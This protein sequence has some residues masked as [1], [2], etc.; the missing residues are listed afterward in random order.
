[1][2]EFVMLVS[3]TLLGFSGVPWWMALPA[4]ALTSLQSLLQLIIPGGRLH[5]AGVRGPLTVCGIYSLFA[6]LCFAA[7]HGMALLVSVG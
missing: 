6:S 5:D 7:G 1:M 2:Y 4:A 3:I